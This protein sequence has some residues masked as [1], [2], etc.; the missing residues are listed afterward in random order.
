MSVNG[1]RYTGSAWNAFNTSGVVTAPVVIFG[2][3]T[4]TSGATPRLSVASRVAQYG[5]VPAARIFYGMNSLPTTWN[6]ANEG[7]VPGKRAF[8]SFKFSPTD[9]LAG[10][11]DARITGYFN[12]VPADRVLYYIYYHEPN[13][14]LSAGTFSA[15]DYKAAHYRIAGLADASTA[16]ARVIPAACYSAPNTGKADGTSTVVWNDSWMIDPTLMPAR[17]II[18][19]DQYTKP[20]TGDLSQPYL[21]L[22]NYVPVMDAATTRLGWNGR[23][24][25]AE[26]N[27]PTR[28][29]DSTEALRIAYLDDQVDMFLACA[30]PPRAV[31]VWDAPDA[32]S[33]SEEFTQT[34]SFAW[35]AARMAT[36][37]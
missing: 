26:F 30:T 11:Y 22:N 37:A 16:A 10:T 8:V 23:W 15:A 5:S 20:L 29:F 18:M 17:S 1:Y 36:S 35:W 31:L 27:T 28:T 33:Y 21:D 34:A 32:S 25:I 19:W 9:I 2:I 4:N 6:T 3:N 13:S 14:S 24:G 12:S 7:L